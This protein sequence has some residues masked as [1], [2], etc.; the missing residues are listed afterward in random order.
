MTVQR[1][2][3]LDIDGVLN[4]EF[5]YY[6]GV[7][8]EPRLATRVARLV[9]KLDAQVVVSSDWRHFYS[10]SELRLILNHFGIASQRVLGTTEV[11]REQGEGVRGHEIAQWLQGHGHPVRLAILDDNHEG[12]FNMDVVREWFVKTNP[13]KGILPA[14]IQQAHALLTGGPVWRA[15]QSSAA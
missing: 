13:R 3:M 11:P 8:I 5:K 12:R 15:V 10:L 6:D 1:I 9:A 2:V 4:R 14:N 7:A